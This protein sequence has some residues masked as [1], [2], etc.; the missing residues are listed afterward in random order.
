M[1][2]TDSEDLTAIVKHQWGVSVVLESA[3]TAEHTPDYHTVAVFLTS[4]EAEA[5]ALGVG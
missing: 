4:E 3:G 5:F 2:P 1:S